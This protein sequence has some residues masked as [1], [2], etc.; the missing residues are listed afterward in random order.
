MCQYIAYSNGLL[1]FK[2]VNFN[3]EKMKGAIQ[4]NR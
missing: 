4:F 1:N 3:N 2:Q